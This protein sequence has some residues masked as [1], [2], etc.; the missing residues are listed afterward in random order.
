MS[1]SYL[2]KYRGTGAR[3]GVK[4]KAVKSNFKIIDDDVPWTGRT[5][6][7]EEDGPQVVNPFAINHLAELDDE[8]DAPQVDTGLS[9]GFRPIGAERSIVIANAEEAEVVQINPA[10]FK[11]RKRADQTARP[12]SHVDSDDLDVPRRQRHDSPELTVPRKQR[13][14]SP[15]LA[16]PRNSAADRQ[17][18][19]ETAV[20]RRGAS[21]QGSRL[22]AL[23]CDV[24]SGLTLL[25]CVPFCFFLWWV[26]FCSFVCLCVFAYVGVVGVV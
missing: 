12:A 25:S 18:S 10:S 8:D 15:D 3:K 7:L 13:H 1:S 5:E 17:H 24:S 16:V 20:P 21:S 14:D 26:P 6:E 4:H 2:D 9:S 19:P 22:A 23:A 11:R